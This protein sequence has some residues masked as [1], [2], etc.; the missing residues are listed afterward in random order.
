MEY[1]REQGYKN[2]KQVKWFSRDRRVGASDKAA[3][4]LAG[5]ILRLQRK[6]ALC[7][8]RCSES[9]GRKQKF[10]FLAAISITFM[11]MSIV[12]IVTPFNRK[13][14]IEKPSVTVTTRKEQV[15][16]MPRITEEEF[17]SVQEFKSKLDSVMI[18]NRP[19]LMDSI[20]MVEELY[21]SN[22]K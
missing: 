8:E 11:T 12:A 6:F 19:G 9:W 3:Q 14:T 4:G 5:C 22:L 10:I 20:S 21:H 1:Y 18:Q 15:E 7:M 2:R 17:R 16:I 13:Y